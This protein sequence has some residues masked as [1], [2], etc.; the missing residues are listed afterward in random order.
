MI[1]GG[2]H[3]ADILR[4]LTGKEAEEVFAYGCRAR[5]DFDYDTT[6]V[7]SVKF[8][9]GSLGKIS[10]SLD[11][12]G[13]PYQLNIDLLGTEGAIRDNRVYSKKLF[14]EQTDFVTL[15]SA[16][17]NSGAVGHH[18][19]QQEIDNLVDGILYGAP[20][21]SDVTDACDSMEMVLAI[22]R[23]AATGKPVKVGGGIEL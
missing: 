7:A 23:S 3:A 12:L 5:P 17:P 21:I 11:G 1:T 13:F 9:D 18:P 6:L 4:Y 10:A 22:E 16:T 20:V 2:C 8:R 14:P 19:F 15:P